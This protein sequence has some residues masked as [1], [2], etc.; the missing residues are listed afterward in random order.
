MKPGADEP[1]EMHG[2]LRVVIGYEDLES[3]VR[4][5]GVHRRTLERAVGPCD[6]RIWKFEPLGIPEILAEA[7]RD[8]MA[9]D[10]V[11]ISIAGNRPLPMEAVEW[12]E[13]CVAER[14]SDEGAILFVT[15]PE[16][17]GEP[18]AWLASGFLEK[19]A[20]EAKFQYFAPPVCVASAAASSIAG[21][22]NSFVGLAA[23]QSCQHDR[24]GLN[25]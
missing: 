14:R 3:G 19:L 9:A 12:V 18:A 4:A 13:R 5:M 6:V 24:W 2:G 25:E 15:A 1:N 17:Q 20:Q 10:V 11:I 22:R 7:T 16:H 8:L 23:M 21:F